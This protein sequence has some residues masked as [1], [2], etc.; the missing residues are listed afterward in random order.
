MKFR[1]SDED[2]DY[3]LRLV[4]VKIEKTYDSYDKRRRA[5]DSDTKYVITAVFFPTQWLEGATKFAHGWLLFDIL[6]RGPVLSNLRSRATCC[7]VS[8]RI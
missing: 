4:P 5:K 8:H 3:V 2:Y 6:V 1:S 7:T